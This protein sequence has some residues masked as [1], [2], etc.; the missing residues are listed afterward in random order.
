MSLRPYQLEG[1]EF[2]ATHKVAAMLADEPGLGKSAQ[3]IVAAERLGLDHILI[4]CPAIG[5]VSWPIELAKWDLSQ[6]VIVMVGRDPLTFSSSYGKVFIVS[7]DLLSRGGHLA[8]QLDELAKAGHFDLLILDEGQY[9][10]DTGAKR[11]KFVYRQLSRH[12]PNT[13]V[14]TGT[15]TPNH[16]GELY[17]HV[18]A[19]FPQVARK[20]FPELGT[21]LPHRTE[22][23][24]KFCKVEVT[25]FGRTIKGNRNTLD[26]R[27]ALEPHLLRRRAVDV[28]GE[29]PPLTIEDLSFDNDAVVAMLSPEQ[30]FAL[31]EAG[32]AFDA[33][34]DALEHDGDNLTLP[35]HIATERR[36]LGL[37]KVPLASAWAIDLLESGQDKIILFAH[38]KDVVASLT[39]ALLDYNPVSITGD[40]STVDRSAR[41][42]KFQLDP[43]VR[44]LVGNIQ[45]AGTSITLTASNRVGI[46]EPSW[47]PGDNEQAIRRSYRIGQRRPVVAT[48]L[49][50]AT[51]L[52]SNITR[53]LIRKAGDIAALLDQEENA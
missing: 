44:V 47:T 14:L 31:S 36:A 28:A 5:R 39:A 45:A 34:Y 35:L 21:R 24:D 12:I 49:S 38:H 26:L 53:T 20:L 11:T 23:E 46:V 27:K 8:V 10:K 19:L 18:V 7:Y 42:T 33:A 51:S 13:W 43:S 40:T 2:L 48:Y 15:P 37:A 9:L 17:P 52:D 50:V 30:V 25:P 22:W 3:A 32:A 41:V 29:L 1:I 4:V 6:R 16:N